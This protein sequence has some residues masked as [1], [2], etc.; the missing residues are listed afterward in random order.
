MVLI[1]NVLGCSTRCTSSESIVMDKRNLDIDNS[2]WSVVT[3]SV[4]PWL[5]IY[6]SP[7]NSKYWFWLGMCWGVALGA[8]VGVVIGKVL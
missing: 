3:S 5:S 8:V 7:S 6:R 2:V 4:P 1:G